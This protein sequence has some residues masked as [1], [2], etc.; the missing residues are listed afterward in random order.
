[1][2]PRRLDTYTKT[3]TEDK[4]YSIDYRRWLQ[5]GETISDVEASVTASEFVDP[6]VTPL[7]VNDY[8]ANA[9]GNGIVYNAE[10]GDHGETYD[11]LFTVT[12]SSGQ[13]KQDIVTFK[14]R[15]L[16]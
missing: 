1:M 9:D 6:A 8:Q 7:L 5:S 15:S 3:P 2:Q 16:G 13:V 10:A 14:I 12:T 4:N 11:V